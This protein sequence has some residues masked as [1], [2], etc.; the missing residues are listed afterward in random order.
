MYAAQVGTPRAD[1]GICAIRMKHSTTMKARHRT[2]HKS[3]KLRTRTHS[4]PMEVLR[5]ESRSDKSIAA[6]TH[7]ARKA[8]K[9]PVVKIVAVAARQRI[10]CAEDGK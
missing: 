6:V 2:Y 1:V 8:H 9:G 5:P 3:A 4:I 7:R 10:V